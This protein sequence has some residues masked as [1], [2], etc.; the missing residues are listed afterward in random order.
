M[1][2]LEEDL[3]PVGRHVEAMER[4]TGF[5]PSELSPL[6]GS[7]VEKPEVLPAKTAELHDER[8]SIGKEAIAVADAIDQ[9]RRNG[10][11]RAISCDGLQWYA[12][13]AW[14]SGVENE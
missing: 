14:S 13:P 7:E 10:V 2:S 4:F 5:E 1:N 8:L 6:T 11:W 3:H 9:D 12:S